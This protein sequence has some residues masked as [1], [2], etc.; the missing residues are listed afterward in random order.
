[1]E[2]IRVEKIVRGG[3]I[4]IKDLLETIARLTGFEG[5]IRWDTS[6]PNGQ[7]RRALDTKRAWRDFG[8]RATTDIETGLRKTIEWYRQT[9]HLEGSKQV[10]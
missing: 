9:L 5:E 2:A 3:Q 1:M 7:P 4:T 10:L 6:K 8:F